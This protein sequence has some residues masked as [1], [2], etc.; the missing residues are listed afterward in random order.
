VVIVVASIVAAVTEV[1]V[2]GPVIK[3]RTCSS[4]QATV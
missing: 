1:P 4:F 3:H 2:A